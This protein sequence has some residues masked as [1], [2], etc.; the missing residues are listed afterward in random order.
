MDKKITPPDIVNMKKE[1]RRISML[2]AYDASFARMLD[3]A[4]V[5]IVLVGDSLGMVVLGYES[6][7][8]VT[9]D[10]MLHH[11]KAA[12]NGV[13]RALLVGD[14]P[15]MSYQVDV[16]DAIANAGR[17][18]KEAGCDAVKL[19]GGE[20]ACEAVAAIVRAGIPVMGHIG[21]TPQTAGKLGGFKV[22]GKDVDSA[23]KLIDAAR[24]IEKAGAFSLVLE[25]IPDQLGEIITETIS[26]PT[27]GIGAGNKCDGQVL[28]TH[29]LLGLFE[30]FIP[31][32]VKSY[33]N[34]AP[35]IKDAVSTYID[36]V[37]DG[38]FPAPEH[39]FSMQNDLKKVLK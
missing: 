20:E 10:E 36:E 28:V 38:S 5:D 2:T 27:F 35:Q 29:D 30:K 6:T 19:E 4:G 37:R 31:R 33:V 11:C 7:V 8:P 23:R 39:C 16:R 3:Q 26:I 9:M 12:R 22:Q 24:S 17:F 18:V 21:L 1:G 32:F 15:F 14:M 13:S 34:L 25:C